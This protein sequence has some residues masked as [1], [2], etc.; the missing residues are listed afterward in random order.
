MTLNS[1]YLHLKSLS[2]LMSHPKVFQSLA[3]ELATGSPV[4]DHYWPLTNRFDLS[5]FCRP[6]FDMR[7]RRSVLEQLRYRRVPRLP[8]Y[9]NFRG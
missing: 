8:R 2:L 7:H 3:V 5:A 1:S 4:T 9:R 6:D